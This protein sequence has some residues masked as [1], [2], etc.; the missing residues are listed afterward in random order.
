MSM[1]TRD[2]IPRLSF[3]ALMATQS[4]TVLNDNLFKQVVLLLALD[5]QLQ[6]STLGWCTDL[7][8]CTGMLFAIPFLL[9][10]ALAGDLADRYSK[11]TIILMTKW[12]EVVIMLLAAVAF[13]LGSLP[14]VVL[15]LFLMGTQSAFL[16][17]AKYGALVE[18]VERKE[19]SHGNGIMQAIVLASILLGLGV[20]G[21]LYAAFKQGELWML[22]LGYALIAC[23]GALI[24]RRISP[25][26]AADPTRMLRRNPF[27]PALQGFRL[28][29]QTPGL[30]WAV[31]GHA[32]YWMLGATLVFAWNEM[33]QNIFAL[34]QGPWTARLAALSLSTAL[35]C[36]L[37]GKLCKERI[38]LR[39]PLLGGLSLA[40]AF[41]A[42]AWGPRT[43]DF[44]WISLLIGSFFAGL[45]LIPLRTLVQRLP[46]PRHTG[47]A[48]GISQLSDWMG[49]VLASFAKTALSASG[50]DAIDVFA[51][52]AI[53]LAA[54][55]ILV[56]GQLARTQSSTLTPSK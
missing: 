41:A 55:T 21:F 13:A 49:I 35:G 50:L 36:L 56:T 17:P 10:A 28:C 2:G 48:L 7:Q 24:A 52:M 14:A 26:P 4:L 37:A 8:A 38:P 22:G 31:L 1:P 32:L 42:V 23:A 45:Y 16:G 25:L 54:G 44:I 43:P 6:G 53:I 40:A 30:S 33:G 5:L 9:F 47:R 46:D 15:V 12:A 29:A 18:M 51:V 19:L 34:D 11:R 39:W 20:A 3:W 27:G